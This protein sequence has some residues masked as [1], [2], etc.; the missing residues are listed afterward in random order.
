MHTGYD[1][2]NIWI[3]FTSSQKSQVIYILGVIK[4]TSKHVI[5]NVKVFEILI[6]S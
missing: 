3:S 1:C 4:L 6:L 2:R 5:L